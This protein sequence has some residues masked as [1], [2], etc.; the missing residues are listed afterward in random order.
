MLDLSH[1][2]E[3][4]PTLQTERFLLRAV[5]ADA[6]DAEALFRLMSDPHVNRYL[7]QHPMASMAQAVERVQV[8]QDA[9]SDESG[10]AWMIVPRGQTGLIGTC[11]LFN[12]AHSH[13]RG[14]VGYVLAPEWWRGGV[15]TEVARAVLDFGFGTMGLHSVEAHIDPANDASRRLLE[16][17]GFVQEGYFREDFFHPVEQRFT[18]TAMFSLI[19]SDWTK[20]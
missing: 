2:F 6:A 18:D 4:F 9:F 5:E 1:A 3:H 15:M 19:V 14:E 12:L 8:F 7:G 11:A 16:K 20:G 13:F 10:I 17:L